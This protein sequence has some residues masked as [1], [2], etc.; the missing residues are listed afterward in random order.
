MLKLLLPHPAALIKTGKTETLVIADPHLGWELALQEKGIHVPSQTPRI[1]QKLVTLLSEQKPDAL[2]ILGDVKYT[3][4]TTE[5]G[6]WHDIPEFFTELRNQVSNIAIVRGNHDA[7]LEPLLP[8]NIRML[9]ATGTIIG[10]VGLFHG[11]KWP[12]PALLGCKTL[13][14]GHLHPVVVFCDP[15]GFKMTQQVW[16]KATCDTKAL[17]KVLLQ[18]HGVKVEGT[19]E[20]TLQKHYKVKPKATQIFMMP[21]FN[22]SLGGR[23]VNET[24]RRKQ[25]LG[26]EA[27]IGPVLQSKAVEVDNAELYLLDGTYLGTLNQLRR[28]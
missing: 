12:S 1:L 24:R 21:S 3:V 16:M 22:D 19:V 25:Q 17:A 28:L 6:E 26:S 2:V 14:M 4:V 7:N 9:P 20:A 23:P 27:L 11:H 8:E 5:A 18:K 15:A 13:V 10:D